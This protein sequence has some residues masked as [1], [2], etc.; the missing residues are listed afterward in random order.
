MIEIFTVTTPFFLLVFA[1]YVATRYSLMPTAAI[2]GLNTYVLYFALPCMLFK[3]GAETPIQELV[4]APMALLYLLCAGIIVGFGLVWNR[5]HRLDWNNS[6]FSAL[7]TTF[8][9]TGF[10][11][12]PLLVALLGQAAAGPVII[13]IFIDLVIVSSLCIAI[14]RLAP[15]EVGAFGA[16]IKKSM[17]GMVSNPM[18]WAICLGAVASATQVQ[19][20]SVVMRTIELLGNSASPVALFTIGAVLARSALLAKAGAGAVA[21]IPVNALAGIKLVVHPVLIFTVFSLANAWGGALGIAFDP[22]AI[23]VITLVG[24]LPS[25]SNVTILAERFQADAGQI[26]KIVLVSTAAAFVTFPLTVATLKHILQ[27]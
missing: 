7:I 4:N 2:P 5:K 23:L 27:L 9:N 6:A 10:M 12:V 15:G 3:F 8:P 22:Y 14:S 13:T 21:A 20:P 24:A 11:G 17:R 1:G 16:A 18:P 26:A 25:A 19:L